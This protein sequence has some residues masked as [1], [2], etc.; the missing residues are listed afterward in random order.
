[1]T[2]ALVSYVQ[3]LGVEG[4]SDDVGKALHGLET[5]RP[6]SA[7]GALTLIHTHLAVLDRHAVQMARKQ[8][9]TWDAIAVTLGVSRQAARKRF[10]TIN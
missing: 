4:F 10:R 8:G 2:D 3:S 5:D 7:L 1:M 6:L 9:K